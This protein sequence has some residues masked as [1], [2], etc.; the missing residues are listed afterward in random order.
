MSKFIYICHNNNIPIQ[1]SL[2]IS[3]DFSVEE[4]S[5]YKNKF[6]KFQKK[7]EAKGL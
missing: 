4:K 5:L 3:S 2:Q 7:C 1:T 6:T